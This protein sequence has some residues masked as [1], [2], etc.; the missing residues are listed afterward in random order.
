MT[1]A[2]PRL[3][4]RHRYDENNQD[5]TYKTFGG[6]DIEIRREVRLS[7][8]LR[9]D[10]YKRQCDHDGAPLC[11]ETVGQ[12]WK[13]EGVLAPRLGGGVF[14]AFHRSTGVRAAI[15]FFPAATA[16]EVATK[17]R[18]T[19]ELSALRMLDKSRGLLALIEEGSEPDGARYLVHELGT[20]RL[21]QDLL[22]EWQKPDRGLL[23]P[24]VAAQVR[25]V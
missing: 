19:R 9:V 3:I 7:L 14:A 18:I 17:D 8:D 24:P 23:D 12:H 22:D 20:L 16:R 11:P 21:L 13:V 1:E 2:T 10:V 25:C 15:S 6:D 4:Y 5:L